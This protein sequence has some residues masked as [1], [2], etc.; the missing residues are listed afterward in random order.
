MLFLLT[1]ISQTKL[2]PELIIK[3]IRQTS[4]VC[5]ILSLPRNHWELYA[6]LT[7]VHAI[8]A[9]TGSFLRKEKSISIQSMILKLHTKLSRKQKTSF[10]LQLKWK[11]FIK[12]DTTKLFL[13]ICLTV[14]ETAEILFTG[15]KNRKRL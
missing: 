11:G 7:E 10:M 4:L 12:K 15:T 2:L 5:L 14:M 9:L 3:N 1:E 6:I 8:R 13:V